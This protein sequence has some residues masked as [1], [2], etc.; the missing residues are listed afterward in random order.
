M[1]YSFFAPRVSIDHSGAQASTAE[2]RWQD[3]ELH[4]RFALSVVFRQTREFFLTH[5]DWHMPE[6]YQAASNHLR[7]RPILDS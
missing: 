7:G 3:G 5:L 1:S 6:R 4:G 2:K